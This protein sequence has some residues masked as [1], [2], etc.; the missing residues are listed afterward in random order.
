[1]GQDEEEHKGDPEYSLKW[2][3]K[4]KAYIQAFTDL[5]RISWRRARWM[6][7]DKAVFVNRKRT[8]KGQRKGLTVWIV[9]YKKM[10][11]LTWHRRRFFEQAMDS[12]FELPTIIKFG[13][14]QLGNLAEGPTRTEARRLT[15]LLEVPV[16]PNYWV[17]SHARRRQ[18]V[19]W[20]PEFKIYYGPER[21]VDDED[22]IFDRPEPLDD[23]D[24]QPSRQ[25][26]GALSPPTYSSY[27]PVFERFGE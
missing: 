18:E 26:R 17:G 23:P 7:S 27:S 8:K 1:M 3:A 9:C 14:E 25:P 16:I 21:Y 19:T 11:T 2:D 22:P 6:R 12:V 10:P 15:R 24:D 13:V 4:L 20:P 5:R